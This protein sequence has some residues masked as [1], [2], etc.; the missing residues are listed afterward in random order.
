MPW[1]PSYPASPVPMK[2]S[3]VSFQEPR[4]VPVICRCGKPVRAVNYDETRGRCF[5]SGFYFVHRDGSKSCEA[6]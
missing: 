3:R 5:I 4:G 1:L 6:R 2:R